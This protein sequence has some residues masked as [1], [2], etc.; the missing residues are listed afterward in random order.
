MFAQ[1]F[2]S[3]KAFVILV[4]SIAVFTDSFLYGLIVPILPFMLAQR[5]GVPEQEIQKWDSILLGTYG[6]AVLV[7]SGQLTMN[8][9][10]LQSHS[11]I[12]AY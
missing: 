9:E 11:V 10:L 5:C 4:V 2:R 6:A 1:K 3:S 8:M 12:F 7:G